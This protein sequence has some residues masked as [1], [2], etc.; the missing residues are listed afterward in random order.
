MLSIGPNVSYRFSNNVT[1][2]MGIDYKRTSG[3]RLGQVHQEID[4]RLNA[5]FKF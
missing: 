2:G 5:E 4:V 1:G 3:G